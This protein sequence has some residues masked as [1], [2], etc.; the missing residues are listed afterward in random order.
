MSNERHHKLARLNDL[1]RSVPFV[2]KAALANIVKNI[3]D[4]GV[5]ELASRKHILECT[6]SALQQGCM[7][8]PLLQEHA[9]E[10]LDGTVDSILLTNFWSYMAALFYQGGSFADLLLENA[11]AIGMDETHPLQLCLY[12]DEVI[13]GNILGKCERKTWALYAG[14]LNFN[15][16]DLG[17]EYAWVLI[18]AVKATRVA[19]LNAGIGQIIAVVLKSIFFNKLC[20]AEGGVLL[21]SQKGP[22][23]RMYIG[24]SAILQD[25]SSH[26]YTFSAKGDSG[27][28]YCLLCSANGTVVCGDMEDE[29]QE[30]VTH[31][32]KLS[33]V[34]LHTDNE[35]L[36]SFDRLQANHATMTKKDFVLWQQACGLTYHKC[37]RLLD[38]ELRAAKILRPA[39]QY[40]HDWMHCCVSAGIFQVAIFVLCSAFPNSWTMLEQ[41]LELWTWPSHLPRH[42][43]ALFGAKHSKKCKEAK[44]FSCQASEALTL[45]PVLTYFVRTILQSKGLC[46]D[47]CEAFLKCAHVV[48]LVHLGQVW[49]VCSPKLLQEAAENCLQS[50]VK[51]GLE[52]KMI[53]KI[54]WILHLASALQRHKKLPSCFSMERKHRFIC[55]YASNICNTHVFEKSLMQELLAEELFHLSKPGVFDK[56]IHLVNGHT[57]SKP[58]H[59]LMEKVFGQ[60]IP[61]GELLTSAKCKLPKSLCSKQD[62][63]L[64]Y[65]FQAVQIVAF[66]GWA[67]KIYA[68]VTMLGLLED[69]E[70][71]GACSWLA[72]EDQYV[73]PATSLL[74]PLVYSRDKGKITTLV[75]W[76]VRCFLKRT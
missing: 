51:A 3:Q 27:W 43:S 22:S 44:K 76:Q 26:K 70:E 55:K 2:S 11:N 35:L 13:P 64:M 19:Q 31:Q 59:A 63:A 25:G 42:V 21:P 30:V 12:A 33:Q 69:A 41:Y 29:S 4:K 1:K 14:F 5:P 37:A 34:L 66:L 10:K 52:D 53:K 67:G 49:G 18:G 20:P 32:L 54:H 9:V 17:S 38:P 72:T 71:N 75:P 40:M 47:I 46:P 48:E 74:C 56:T 50:W 39:Q 15:L 65:P 28:K 62:I 8:G 36:E 24:L 58:F 60:R 45:L 23:L 68:W 6:Q 57:P 7:Y 16:E 73:V 61:H